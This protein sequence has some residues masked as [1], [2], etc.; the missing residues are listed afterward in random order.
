MDTFAISV[1]N[2]MTIQELKIRQGLT[3][4]LYLTFFQTLMPVIGWMAG[5]GLKS[6]IM[7]MD[8]WIA[9]G[10]LSAIGARMI[11]EGLKEKKDKPATDLKVVRLIGQAIATSIDSLVIGLSF[12]FLKITILKPVLIIG[13]TT[14]IASV[15]GLYLGK[16][17]STRIDKKLEVFGGLILIGIGTKILIE[18][19]GH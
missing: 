4:A 10:L 9:F 7:A 5:L 14:F 17:Y 6:Y 12:V 2:G 3:I 15:S 16:L 1:S 19:L 18:H 13:L 11:Y 8:H